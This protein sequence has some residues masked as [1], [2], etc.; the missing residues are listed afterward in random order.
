MIDPSIAIILEGLIGENSIPSRLRNER[1]FDRE[2]YHDVVA[3]IAK[4]IEFYKD[5]DSVP[6]LLSLCFVD[7]SNHF[8]VPGD[9][10]FT[11][12]EIEEI[13]DAGIHLSELANELFQ[14]KAP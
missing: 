7:I 10:R 3:A 13:E 2:R 8:F 9:G 4:A 1:V 6:K 11:E 5:H 12:Q 14:T